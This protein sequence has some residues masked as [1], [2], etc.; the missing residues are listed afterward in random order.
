MSDLKKNYDHKVGRNDRAVYEEFL[1]KQKE[2]KD[3]YAGAASNNYAS[4][5]HYG[6][7][8]TGFEKYKDVVPKYIPDENKRNVMERKLLRSQVPPTRDRFIANPLSSLLQPQ[9]AERRQAKKFFH[10]DKLDV[11]DIDGARTNT[12][13]KQK[14]IQGRNYM[15]LSDIEKTKPQ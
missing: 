14:L 10:H 4:M 12:Y 5:M 11:T 13:G 8:H 1:Q 9:I 7:Q 2:L 3:S 6:T 15:D